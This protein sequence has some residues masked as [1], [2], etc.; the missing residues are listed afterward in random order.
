MIWTRELRGCRR[1]QFDS[2]VHELQAAGETLRHTRHVLHILRECPLP[3][4]VPLGHLFE[5]WVGLDKPYVQDIQPFREEFCFQYLREDRGTD[6]ILPEKNVLQRRHILFPWIDA[7]IFSQPGTQFGHDVF[8]EHSVPISNVED[9]LQTCQYHDDDAK[10]SCLPLSKPV[11][12]R[13]CPR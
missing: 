13:A 8:E 6:E 7:K 9:L 12:L 10:D 4:R 5:A 3:E 1:P 11:D 2:F